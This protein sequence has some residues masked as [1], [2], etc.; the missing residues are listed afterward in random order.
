MNV[1]L[2]RAKHFLFV[3]ARCKSIVVNPYWKDLV[4]HARETNAVVR[5][6]LSKGESS[7]KMP[8][9]GNVEQWQ[10]EKPME[11]VKPIA[12]TKIESETTSEP[13]DPR[14]RTKMGGKATEQKPTDPRKRANEAT[15]I[16]T[17]PRKRP[18]AGGKLDAKPTDPRKRL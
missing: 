17:D 8:S 15:L 1:A 11:E 5:V 18:K 14:K 12:P 3:I 9:F 6:P 7:G 16:P 4:Q 10:L 13:T 2:T